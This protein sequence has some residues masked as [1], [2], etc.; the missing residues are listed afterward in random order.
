MSQLRK[1][2]ISGRWVIIASER[3]KRPDD[4]RSGGPS[5]PEAPGTFCPFCSGSETK[6]PPEVYALRQPGTRPDQPGWR[7]RVVPNKFPALDRG[8]KCQRQVEGVFESMTGI[9]VHEVIIESPDHA[10]ELCDLPLPHLREVLETYQVRIRSIEA[11]TQYQYVQVFKNKGREA[12]A[13]LS[14]P[15]SQIVATP[16]IPKRIKEELYGADRLFKKLEGCVFCRIVDQEIRQGRRVVAQNTAFCA[17]SPFASRFPFEVHIYPL[18]H[19]AHFAGI[20]PDEIGSLASVLKTVLL[21]LKALLSDPP[22]NI[23]VHQAPN[24][25]LSGGSWPALSKEYHWHI[26]ILPVLTRVAGFELGT[27]FYINPVPPEAAAEF[28]AGQSIP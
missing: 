13:S 6:T 2:L 4:F 11:E 27:G 20:T 17:V 1:D 16:I 21:K 5:R 8:E 7:V 28:L 18:R 12:G 19:S 3:S 24:P 15:H 25:G 26:E 14:H 23:V 10:V 22:Y 9:G